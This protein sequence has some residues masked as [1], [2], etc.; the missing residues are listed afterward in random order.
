MRIGVTDSAAVGQDVQLAHV[1][2]LRCGQIPAF[3]SSCA[4]WRLFP[5]ST[6]SPLHRSAAYG[7]MARAN[8]ACLTLAG[9]APGAWHPWQVSDWARKGWCWSCFWLQGFHSPGS[10]SCSLVLRL[11]CPTRGYCTHL[12]GR[13]LVISPLSILSKIAG[14]VLPTNLLSH[15][16]K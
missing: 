11:L 14:F 5:T 7:R 1:Q 13:R 3:G 12:F 6:R 2:D 15:Q 16:V 10:S 8:F 4:V 9:E